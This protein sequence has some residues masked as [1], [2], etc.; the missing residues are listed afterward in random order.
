MSTAYLSIES[1]TEKDIAGAIQLRLL[2]LDSLFDL[3]PN[4]D[5]KITWGETLSQSSNINNY[6]KENLSFKNKE[7]NCS[8]SPE[9]NQTRN[10]AIDSHF[11]EAYLIIPITSSCNTDSPFTISYSG[12]FEKDSN[13]KLLINS[14]IEEISGNFIISKNKNSVIINKESSFIKTAIE[15]IWQGIIH[16]WI[17]LDHILFLMC[18]LLACVFGAKEFKKAT[19]IIGV[20]SMFTLA[21]SITLTI[22]AMGWMELSSK[23]VEVGIAITILLSAINN[24]FQISS[25]ILLITFGF[26]LLHG[27]GFASVLSELGVA[28]NQQWLSV[29]AFN[30]GVEIGQVVIVLLALPLLSVIKR[31]NIAH[32]FWLVTGSSMIALVSVQWIIQRL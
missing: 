22:I 27:A 15:F 6:L 8:L 19:S 1:T 25:R 21:H 32:R 28:A 30:I 31:T 14:T 26:G 18:L 2:D 29:L 7:N 5:G 10:W 12:F 11:N 16:I 20:V 23:W 9:K 13:H 3:D 24:I 4:K 17:G